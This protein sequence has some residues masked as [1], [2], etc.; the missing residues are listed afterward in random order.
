MIRPFALALI[1]SIATAVC[2]QEQLG[3]ANSNYAGTDAVPLNPARLAGQWPWLD[4]NFIGVDAFAW[5]NHVYL[6][7][8]EHSF[9]GDV[10]GGM[11]GTINDL[12]INESPAAGKR[13]AFA[14]LALRGPAFAISNGISSL[15]A[16]ITTR[17]AVDVVGL[18]PE[19]AHV[20]VNGLGYQP[21]F[22]MRVNEE[23]LRLSS[24]AWTEIGLS[25][26]RIIY[27][28]GYQLI[29]AGATVDYLMAHHGAA[30]R[31]DRLD[32][33][34]NDTA[35]AEVYNA[36]GSYGFAEPG[37][38]SGSGFGVDLGVQFIR[39]ETETD[40]YL[41][42]RVSTGCE[43]LLYT[44]RAGFSILD[45][46]ALSY[47]LPY[48]GNFN[49]ASASYTDYQ[50]IDLDGL[51]AV[52]SLFSAS[53]GLISRDPKLRIGLPTA[54]SG[55]F[56]YR[57][58]DNVYV[59]ANVVQNIASAKSLRLRRMNTLG[60]VPRFETRRFEVALPIVL[61]EYDIRKPGVGLMLRLNNVIVG[62]DHVLPMIARTDIYGLDFY[63]RV[64]WTI[65]KGP[66]CNGKKQL[67]HTPGDRNALPC[68]TP[69]GG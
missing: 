55:Q 13:H 48:T 10:R 50:A 32:F 31:M 59:A 41:P 49:A 20:M 6:S 63:V 61:H 62:S 54:L 44:W 53:L 26:A 3:I 46:G 33:A 18:S 60:I 24:A 35:N 52:D 27:N 65:F 17:A 66:Y 28:Q 4:I 29:T 45:L 43:P 37:L 68:V 36:T 30:L 16:H 5:N 1:G 67:P 11:N 51:P 14:D 47:S 2:A 34:V 58:R 42:H 15:G 8:N 22:G 21:Q 64:K 19:L 39:T 69:P 23:D 12:R 56:D 7:R 38:Q 25:Y 9:W 57:V 40:R